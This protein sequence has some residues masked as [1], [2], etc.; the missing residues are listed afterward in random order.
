MAAE[1]SSAGWR[2]PAGEQYPAVPLL[3]RFERLV[4]DGVRFRVTMTMTPPLVS[5]L[6]DELLLSRYAREIDK[7]CELAGKE[8]VRT[9][10]DPA[11]QALARY[12]RDHFEHTRRTRRCAQIR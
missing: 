3:E 4:N 11:F 2:K 12:Y 5:M 8:V 6:R 9:A 7:L 10:R 1:L